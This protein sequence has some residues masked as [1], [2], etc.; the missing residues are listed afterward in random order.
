MGFFEDLGDKLNTVGQGA[1]KAARDLAG[2]GKLTLKLAEKVSRLDDLYE[3]LGRTVYNA[4]KSGLEPELAESLTE[5]EETE[6][7]VRILKKE[8]ARRRNKKICPACGAR[9]AEKNAYCP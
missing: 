1:K 8:L 7:D 3:E 5:I 6:K 4:H 2:T 9:T